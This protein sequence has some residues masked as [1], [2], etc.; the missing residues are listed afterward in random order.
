MSSRLASFKGPSTPASSPV[1][2]SKKKPLP[3]QKGSSSPASSPS[4]KNLNSSSTPIESSFHRKTRAMLLEMR[5]ACHLWDDLVL[6]DGVKAVR[7]VVD[8]N[9]ELQNEL[10]QYSTTLPSTRIIGPKVSTMER[11][12]VEIDAVI[13]KLRRQFQRMV[14]IVENFDQL[15]AEAHRTK[16]WDWVNETPLWLSWSLSRFVLS[17][18]DILPPYF[19]SLELHVELAVQLKSYSSLSFDESREIVASWVRQS[20]IEEANWDAFWEDVCE[21][22]VEGWES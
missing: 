18:T 2:Q 3:S 10:S 21:A 14:Q 20:E 6:L 1:Q 16:G 13:T 11:G 12:L 7:K 8:T 19:R 9:T 15:L 4:R 5:T 22:E 17:I